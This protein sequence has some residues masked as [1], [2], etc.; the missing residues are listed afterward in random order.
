MHFCNITEVE[1]SGANLHDGMHEVAD[2]VTFDDT[3]TN[4]NFSNITEIMVRDTMLTHLS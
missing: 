4:F 2:R 1:V 3:L